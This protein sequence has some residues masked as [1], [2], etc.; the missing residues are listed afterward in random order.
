M[1]YKVDFRLVLLLFLAILFTFSSF[2]LLEQ[3][4]AVRT[5]ISQDFIDFDYVKVFGIPFIIEDDFT[6][7][8]V[9][10]VAPYRF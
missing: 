5:Q 4:S 2:Q 1:N 9:E 7:C 6:N 8:P 3:K 10:S